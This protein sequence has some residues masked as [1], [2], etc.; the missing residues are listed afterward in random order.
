VALL[1]LAEDLSV[2]R[3]DQRLDVVHA[4]EGRAVDEGS[5]QV[6]LQAQPVGGLDEGGIQI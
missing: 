3:A 6:L 1:V 2:A 4:H 5:R